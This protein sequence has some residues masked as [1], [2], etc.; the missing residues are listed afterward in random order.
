[1]DHAQRRTS[2]RNP[3]L[4]PSDFLSIDGFESGDTSAWNATVP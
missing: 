1:M 3:V 2:G 4:S